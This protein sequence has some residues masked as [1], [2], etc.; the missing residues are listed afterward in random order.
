MQKQRGLIVQ[1][2]SSY[3]GQPF[4]EIATSDKGIKAF[5]SGIR[6]NRVIKNFIG[7]C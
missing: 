3:R 4:I 7:G 1:K 5:L 6:E 2:Q